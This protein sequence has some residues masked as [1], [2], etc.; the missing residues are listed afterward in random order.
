[1]Q[2]SKKNKAIAFGVTFLLHALIAITP[3]VTTKDSTPSAVK[4]PMTISMTYTTPKPT[5]PPKPKPKPKKKIIVPKSSWKPTVGKWS[6]ALGSLAG[7]AGGW[8]LITSY[9]L[10]K[11]ADDKAADLDIGFDEYEENKNKAER[12]NIIGWSLSGVAVAGAALGIW[13]L[14]SGDSKVSLAPTGNGATLMVRF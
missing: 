1:M 11:N 2:V 8:L 9:E 3:V 6:L 10:S 5:P 4:K 12:Y 7:L 13:G 14:T